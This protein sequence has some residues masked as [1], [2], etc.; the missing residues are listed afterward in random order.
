MYLDE[1]ADQIAAELDPRRLPDEGN[2]DRLLRAYAVLANTKGREATLED[3][4][5]VWAAWMAEVDPDHPALKPF[6]ELNESTRQE[7]EPFL[8]AVL[9]VAGR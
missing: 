3:V 5:D 9:A 7:D 6:A 4:H 2:V 8:R 1:I